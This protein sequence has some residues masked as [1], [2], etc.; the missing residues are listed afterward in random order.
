MPRP[1][2][3]LCAEKRDFMEVYPARTEKDFYAGYDPWVGIGTAIVLALFFFI[4]TVK[5][6]VHYVVRKWRMHQFYK[7]TRFAEQPVDDE[8]PNAETA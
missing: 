8:H 7:Q 5:S 6:C 3:P 4:I 1:C 2:H